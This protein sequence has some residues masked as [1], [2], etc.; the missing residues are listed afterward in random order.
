MANQSQLKGSWQLQPEAR[1]DLRQVFTYIA[2]DSPQRAGEFVQRLLD[3]CDRQSAKPSPA[4]NVAGRYVPAGTKRVVEGNYHIYYRQGKDKTLSVLRIVR[5]DRG[6][7]RVFDRT[8][9]RQREAGE[10]S[11]VKEFNR[12]KQ[13]RAD[14]K[15]Y[16]ELRSERRERQR[17]LEI[18]CREKKQRDLELD[19]RQR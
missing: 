6:L 2:R 14:L 9:Q 5:A 8:Y 17:E 12:I 4:R 16:R 19:D 15:R 10:R 7:A 18:K 11:D 1:S 13:E 3:R